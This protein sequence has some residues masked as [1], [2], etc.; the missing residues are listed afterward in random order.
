MY[1]V[2]IRPSLEALED[3]WLPSVDFFGGPVI[4]HVEVNTLFLGQEWSPSAP[5]NLATIKDG[6]NSFL[7]SI[8]NSPYMDMLAQ[9]GVGRGSF[10]ST[11]GEYLTRD[12][13]MTAA[14]DDYHPIS[15][16]GPTELQYLI[17]NAIQQGSLPT[18]DA[19]QLYIV[20]LPPGEQELAP[21]GAWNTDAGNGF[22]G[23][24][25]AFES[26]YGRINYAVLP[27][28]GGPNGGVSGVPTLFDSLTTVVSHELSEAVTDPIPNKGWTD[29][30]N[31]E[32]GDICTQDL[33]YWNGYV[34]Q[35]E[36][37]QSDQP[38]VPFLP[39][40]GTNIAGTAGQS[41]NVPLA[42]FVDHSS[43][44]AGDTPVQPM[45]GSPLPGS[46]FTVRINWGDGQSSSG[47]VV[48][49]GKGGYVV[50]GSHSY[51]QAGSYKISISVT[52]AYGMT[53]SMDSVATIAPGQST[54]PS[55][56]PAG[57]TPPS[58]PPAPANPFD[59]I[60]A[61]ALFLAQSVQTGNLNAIYAG[62]MTFESIL[63]HSPASMQQ[64]LEQAF[65][66]DIF[67]DL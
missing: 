52:D 22:L 66:D 1:A 55:T 18:P 3:R 4:P 17:L 10:G 53:A 23:Y 43:T 9:Y 21:W 50:V 34:V 26:Q 56:P 19:N 29:P 42:A 30:S 12:P 59:E 41:V 49:E 46:S 16:N 54:P 15:P 25:S 20:F 57:A 65:I 47:Q 63:D 2:R 8:V 33:I 62:V 64:Q 31:G 60:A 35:A 6:L 45:G 51:A 39:S 32:I 7:Q 67:A 27:C 14:M 37:N 5:N 28:P 44:V 13:N 36:A 48:Y 58:T 40:A 38:M 61:D 24:H 11:Y